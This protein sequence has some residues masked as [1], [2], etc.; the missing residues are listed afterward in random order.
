MPLQTQTRCPAIVRA[1]PAV[2]KRQ[3]PTTTNNDGIEYLILLQEM[4]ASGHRRTKANSAVVPRG[5][6]EPPTLR[7]SVACSTN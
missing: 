7:F 1:M 4:A 6:I 2:A 5:G 3:N